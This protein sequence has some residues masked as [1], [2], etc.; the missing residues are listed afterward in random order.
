MYHS[1]IMPLDQALWCSSAPSCGHGRSE[2]G[3]THRVE[4]DLCAA[5]PSPSALCRGE[6]PW[7]CAK[8]FRLLFRCK[9]ND[10][11]SLIWIPERSENLSPDSEIGMA[12]M[13]ALRC[14][15]HAECD[16][17]KLI[18]FH[19]AIPLKRKYRRHKISDRA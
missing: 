18:Y 16:T 1:S 5:A 17:A 11:E 3:R 12:H 10:A 8:K 7:M 4:T 9:H 14:F 6:D 2:G 15:S 19:D 13:G